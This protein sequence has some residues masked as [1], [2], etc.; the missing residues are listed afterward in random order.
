MDKFDI[1]ILKLLQENANISVNE[2]S[3]LVGLSVTPCWRRINI[4]EEKGVISKRVTLLDRY[5]LNLG[6]TVIVNIRTNRHDQE[7]FE[8]FSL[9]INEI[10]EVIE[11]YRM[12]GEIDYLLRVVVPSIDA[13]D[14]IYK[15][16]IKINGL[17]DVSSSFAMEQIKSTTTL[18]LSYCL[19]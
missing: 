5:K 18:P 9:L 3:K 1:K 8:E 7:W 13:Y 4:L 10:P 15:K 11:F 2:I 12:S 17:S 19:D 16:I 6:L 14:A